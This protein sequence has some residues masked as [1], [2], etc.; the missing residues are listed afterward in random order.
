MSDRLLL[1]PLPRLRRRQLRKIAMQA[2][3]WEKLYKLAR[4]PTSPALL[5]PRAGQEEISM[6][7]TARSPWLHRATG[8][9]PAPL[10]LSLALYSS[11]SDGLPSHTSHPASPSLS[12]A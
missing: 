1:L 4:A 5:T 12:I 6:Q 3:S 10:S 11:S 2:I 9:R 7:L 8:H